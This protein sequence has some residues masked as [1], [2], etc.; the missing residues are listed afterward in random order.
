MTHSPHLL[1]A[2]AQVAL[3]DQYL[4]NL[5]PGY[6]TQD[7][8]CDAVFEV[9]CQNVSDLQ[10]VDCADEQ[11]ALGKKH[12]QMGTFALALVRALL[13][14]DESGATYRRLPQ[15]YHRHTV[16]SANPLELRRGNCTLPPTPRPRL[17]KTPDRAAPEGQSHGHEVQSAHRI[18]GR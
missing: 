3:E 18:N 14:R 4:G 5:I 8:P 10:T 13:E 1:Q 9:R 12:C 2:M 15:P 7:L 16:P 11:W 17:S 6:L